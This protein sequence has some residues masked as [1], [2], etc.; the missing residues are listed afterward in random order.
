[1]HEKLRTGGGLFLALKFI[2]GSSRRDS[3]KTN[4]TSI[5]EDAGLIPG[6]SGLRIQCC[7][8]LWC[9]PVAIAPIGP[10]AWEPPY[11]VDVA[12]KRHTHKKKKFI[13]ELPSGHG[14]EQGASSLAYSMSV[15]D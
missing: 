3:V 13:F 15:S 9:R 4:L 5:H 2:F 7:R 12:L 14:K 10:L 6:L 1:M 11:A 8:E